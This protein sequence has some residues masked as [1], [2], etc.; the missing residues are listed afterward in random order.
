VEVQVQDL[1]DSE[2][3]S[4]SCPTMA[5]AS[6]ALSGNLISTRA[7]EDG[8]ASSFRALSSRCNHSPTGRVVEVPDSDAIGSWATSDD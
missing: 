3:D 2:F 8:P 6:W 1:A 5:L 4:A 7:W